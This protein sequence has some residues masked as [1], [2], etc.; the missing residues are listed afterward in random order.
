MIKEF[1]Q[2]KVKWHEMETGLHKGMKNV[3]NDK[4]IGKYIFCA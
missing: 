1:F 2:A 4:H 3:R